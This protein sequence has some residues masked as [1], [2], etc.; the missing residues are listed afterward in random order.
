MISEFFIDCGQG[1]G[2]CYYYIRSFFIEGFNLSF[3]V[4][5]VGFSY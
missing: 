2:S 5:F 3:I 1:V 4:C